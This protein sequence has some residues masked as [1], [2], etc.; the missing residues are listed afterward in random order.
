MSVWLNRAGIVKRH[1]PALLLIAA[2]SGALLLCGGWIVLIPVGQTAGETAPKQK[3]TLTHAER[4][5]LTAEQMH[6]AQ[7]R[8]S[9]DDSLETQMQN[10]VSGEHG[11]SSPHSRVTCE[12]VLHAFGEGR[13]SLQLEAGGRW[14]ENAARVVFSEFLQFSRTLCPQTVLKVKPL[15]H[16]ARDNAPQE[17]EAGGYRVQVTLYEHAE[18]N[19]AAW[20][21]MLIELWP[22]E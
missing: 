20:W 19:D 4:V 1:W 12:W 17:T 10:A 11:L 2:G 9:P 22:L 6:K 18:S 13:C 21:Q 8:A 14:S 15:V 5:V 7:Y 16:Y 3:T